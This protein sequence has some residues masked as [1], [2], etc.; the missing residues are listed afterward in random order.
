MADSFDGPEAAARAKLEGRKRLLEQG[1]EMLQLTGGA[2]RTALR[3]GVRTAMPMIEMYAAMRVSD[4]QLEQDDVGGTPAPQFLDLTPQQ[5]EVVKFAGTKVATEMLEIASITHPIYEG[6]APYS[7][8]GIE[9]KQQAPHIRHVFS[10]YL[11]GKDYFNFGEDE[12]PA[13]NPEIPIAQFNEQKSVAY[14]A[15]AP[16]EYVQSPGPLTPIAMKRAASRQRTYQEP[17]PAMLRS[18]NQPIS[19][20]LVMGRSGQAVMASTVVPISAAQGSNA[21]VSAPART[22]PQ[23]S[24]GYGG[25]CG[26]GG[27]SD[28]GCGCGHTHGHRN[29]PPTRYNDDGTCAPLGKV[30]CDTQWRVRECFKI[31]FCDMLRCLADEVC[32]DGQFAQ[33]PDAGKCLEG[34]VCSLLHCL[35]DAICPPPEKDDCCAA[36]PEPSCNCN[37]AVGE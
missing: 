27:G 26:C 34:F 12:V 35:P 15:V 37:F 13:P 9:G 33:E 3:A 28:C 5:A 16:G 18:N 23:S 2:G 24:C 7:A 8:L 29:F 20:P 11:A 36:A 17:E 31:A 32:E 21:Y 30:S 14:L 10:L 6:A 22:A 19:Q 1:I 25:G 4:V